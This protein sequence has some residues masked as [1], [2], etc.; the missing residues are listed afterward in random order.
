MERLAFDLNQQHICAI[1]FNMQTHEVS[2]VLKE[3]Y[4]I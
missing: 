4:A 2:Y 3:I 1:H